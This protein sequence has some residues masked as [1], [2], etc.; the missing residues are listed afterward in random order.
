[1]MSIMIKT[2]TKPTSIIVG[3]IFNMEF[4]FI[5]DKPNAIKSTKK[6]LKNLNVLNAKIMMMPLED[7]L[8]G[9]EKSVISIYLGTNKVVNRF[10]FMVL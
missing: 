9:W 3:V 1:M 5:N 4:L 8:M 10:R 7:C 6:R 2:A